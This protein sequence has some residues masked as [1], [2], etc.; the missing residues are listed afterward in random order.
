L[1]GGCSDGIVVSGA[2]TASKP[3]AGTSKEIGTSGVVEFGKE[4]NAVSVLLFGASRRVRPSVDVVLAVMTCM[5]L[6]D[7]KNPEMPERGESLF[8][9][10]SVRSSFG[11]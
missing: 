1:V 6:C 2:G 7:F 8:S 3:G 9:R 4:S 5:A 10:R 11:K